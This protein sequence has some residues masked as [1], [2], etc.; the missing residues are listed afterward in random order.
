[1]NSSKTIFLTLLLA[2]TQISHTLKPDFKN[3]ATQYCH[4]LWQ[5]TKKIAQTTFDNISPSRKADPRILY[6]GALG[7]ITA[8]LGLWIIKKGVD[9]LTINNTKLLQKHLGHSNNTLTRGIITTSLG[10][11]CALTGVTL[12]ATSKPIITRLG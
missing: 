12:V 8:C 6:L 9:T 7:F 11:L 1:M 2:T 5:G 3:N 10:V 4:N